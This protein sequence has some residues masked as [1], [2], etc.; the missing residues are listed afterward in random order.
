MAVLGAEDVVEDDDMLRKA[1]EGAGGG[2]D[3]R[4]RAKAGGK[5]ALFSHVNRLSRT[6][7]SFRSIVFKVHP[8]QAVKGS[9]TVLFGIQRGNFVL[10]SRMK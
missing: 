3:A 8:R 9:R 2:R 4:E 10:Y 7:E 5:R 1:R 6:R